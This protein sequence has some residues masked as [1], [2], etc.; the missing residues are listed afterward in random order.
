MKKFSVIL[1]LCVLYSCAEVQK[2]LTAQNIIDKAI[3]SSGGALYKES[4]IS[5]FFRGK[6]Y[7]SD[8][9]EGKEVLK[10]VT[11][12]DTLKI[13]DV[14][15][16]NSFERFFNDSLVSVPDSMINRFSNSINSVHYFAQ[17][18]YGLNDKAVKKELLGEITI[19][20]KEYYKIKVTF[21]Q[22]NGG[23]DFD[24]T[25]I[26]WFNKETFTPDYLAYEFH[27]DGGGIRFREAYNERYINNIRF[28]DYHN[29]KTNNKE[30]SI[31]K[32]DSLF[33]NGELK[34]LSNIELDSI[35][36]SSISSF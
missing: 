13:T 28:V 25:Y 17:L 27:V 30:N 34:F 32:I 9:V 10:R 15:K 31:Y 12:L 23:D 3:L 26:Y 1:L 8:R 24:D 5:F 11:F 36:V 18:P 4:K 2:P 22:E 33:E 19:K 7:I 14:K 6:K 29:L 20:N 21:A 35:K 16:N